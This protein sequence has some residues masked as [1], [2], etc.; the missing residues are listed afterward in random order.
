M[1]LYRNFAAYLKEFYGKR[2][3]KISVNGGFTCPNRDG[4]KG[5]GGC[6]YC[7][8]ISFSPD[9]TVQ[10]KP[11]FQQIEE[12]IAYFAKKYPT[13]KYIAYF[14]NYTNTYA[15]V[16]ELEIKYAEA[17]KH[18]DVVALA[19]STR[20]DCVNKEVLE[21]LAEINREKKVFLELG[22]EST[23][24]ETL[25][26]I[27]RCHTFEDVKQAVDLVKSYGLWITMHLIFGLPGE[28][29]ED[30]LMHAN[31]ISALQVDSVKLHQLQVIKGS[32]LERIYKDNPDFINPVSLDNYLEWVIEFLENLDST[33]FV[34]RFTSESPVELVVSPQWGNIKN[35]HVVEMLK[36][37]MEMLN[38]YQ[39]RCKK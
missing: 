36:K 38:T 21:L 17:L 22:V 12:G 13:Q 8:N 19:I 14:Q 18:P 37:R 31:K 4:T 35:Y 28:Q 3:Q 32:P 33:I 11:I 30:V 5:V 25:K 15:P 26:L 20:P 27:H 24:E 10:Q 39:G 6:I 9:Y 2:V 7:D 34:E 16:N 23:K 1:E 29:K